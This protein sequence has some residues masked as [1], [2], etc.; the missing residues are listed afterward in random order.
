MAAIGALRSDDAIALARHGEKAGA[1][2]L[3]LTSISCTP[4][5]EDEVFAHFASVVEATTLPLCIYINP[6]TTQFSFSLPLIGRLAQLPAVRGVKMPLHAVLGPVSRLRQPSGHLRRGQQLTD[7]QPQRLILPP[8]A[9]QHDR[10]VAALG[11]LE[12]RGR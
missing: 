8:P 5:T 6:T 11:S 7:A 1:A 9:A 10:L 2:S 4:L 12:T 3:L